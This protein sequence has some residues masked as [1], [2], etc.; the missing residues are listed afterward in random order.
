MIRK[1]EITSFPPV[2]LRWHHGQL[3]SARSGPDISLGPLR[4]FPC[5]ALVR[6]TFKGM[7][8]SLRVSCLHSDRTRDIDGVLG[9]ALMR[10]LCSSG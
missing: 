6:E 10:L 5:G 2:N 1:F 9:S 3:C 7:G 8:R 4:S